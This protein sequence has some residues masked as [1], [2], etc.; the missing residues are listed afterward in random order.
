MKNLTARTP[1]RLLSVPKHY[2]RQ[3]LYL[4]VTGDIFELSV[5]VVTLLN[6]VVMA[7]EFEGISK[8]KF[9]IFFIYEVDYLIYSFSN[10][11]IVKC[12]FFKRC[13]CGFGVHQLCICGTFYD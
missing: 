4:F 2:W 13:K 5:M 12:N 10:G 7:L 11:I 9:I 8:S 6:L 1:S 3:R